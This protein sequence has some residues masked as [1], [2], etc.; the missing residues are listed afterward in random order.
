MEARAV[1]KNVR[2]S[3]RKVRLVVDQIRGRSVNDAHAILRFSK[4]TAAEPVAK[5]LNSAVAN[6]QDRAQDQD[7]WVDADDLRV[8]EAYVD[9]GWTLKRF[10]AGAMGRAKPRDRRASHITIVVDTEE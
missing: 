10:K 2:M 6:A 8:R 1:K 3:P 9:E 4:K 7:D 5:T